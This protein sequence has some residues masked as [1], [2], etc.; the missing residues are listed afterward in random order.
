MCCP[1]LFHQGL[2]LVLELSPHKDS[3][4]L[5]PGWDFNPR[6]SNL[7][8][9]ALPTE[10]PGQNRGRLWVFEIKINKVKFS[11]F[12]SCLSGY[13]ATLSQKFLWGE[14]FVT[15]RKTTA[16]ETRSNSAWPKRSGVGRA[17]GRR[18]YARNVDFLNLSR[19]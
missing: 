10:S 1:Q 18:A 2:I 5:R 6:P 16:K 4:K 13:H 7:I 11:L 9:V 12:R 8:T 15:S 19:W 14:R 3:K 17:N